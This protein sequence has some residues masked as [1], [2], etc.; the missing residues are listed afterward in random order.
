MSDPSRLLEETQDELT[1][2]LLREARSGGASPEGRRR[3][4]QALGLGVMAP[5][6]TASSLP[7][8]VSLGVLVVGGV[9][10]LFFALRGSDRVPVAPVEVVRPPVVEVSATLTTTAVAAPPETAASAAV[11]AP[12]P[13]PAR[14]IPSASSGSSL[15]LEIAAIDRARQAVYANDKK[16][17]ESALDDYDRRFPK[18]VLAPEAAKLRARADALP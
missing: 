13:L 17:A 10:L 5:A 3:T 6:P 16:G 7:L 2:E 18:G 9:G 8:K 15:A 1:R 12:R 14:V 4:L 11:A